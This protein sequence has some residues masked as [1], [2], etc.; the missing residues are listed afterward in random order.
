MGRLP[1]HRLPRRRRGRAGQPQREATDALFPRARRRPA[2]EL[3]ARCVLDGEIVI[4]GPARPG[5]RRAV[6]THPPGREAHPPARRVDAGLLCRL[7]P[8]GRRGPLVHGRAVC[9]ATRRTGKGAA[10]GATAR[11]PHAGHPESRRGGGLVLPLRGRRARR[12]RGEGRRAHLPARQ[13]GHAQGQTPA[14]GGLR[15]GGL[16]HAQGRCRRGLAPPRPVRCRRDAAPCRRGVG[17]QRGPPARA[18]RRA[19]AL[20]EGRAEGPPVGRLGRCPGGRPGS[21]RGQPLERRQ[22]HDLGAIAR[23]S[24]GRG[25]LR[26]PAA[27]PLPP[28]HVLRALAPRPRPRRR[29]PT[30]SSTRRSRWS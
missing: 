1:L 22:G 23:R 2:P 19:R 15:G 24:G 8:A 5:V 16:P 28:R 30:P 7:R 14:H 25:L 10:Q 29:A 20:S 9:T 6:P 18:G 21:G 27:G 26:P 4:A 17:V 11:P 3:P 12:R 13:A